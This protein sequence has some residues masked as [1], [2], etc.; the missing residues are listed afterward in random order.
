MPATHRDEVSDPSADLRALRI[1]T[2]AGVIVL[3]TAVVLTAITWI[4]TF[5]VTVSSVAAYLSQIVA[6]ASAEEPVY[7]TSPV[8]FAAKPQATTALVKKEM[9]QEE[10][11][12]TNSRVRQSITTDRVLNSPPA[13]RAL[14]ERSPS[15]APLSPQISVARVESATTQPSRAAQDQGSSGE[16][17]MLAENAVTSAQPAQKPCGKGFW[18][19]IC[20]ERMRWSY[21]HPDKWDMVPK[22]AVQKFDLSY[23]LD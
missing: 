3:V 9:R 17:P 22:C 23:S 7:I 5:L 1:D 11:E 4:T 18:G 13:P 6:V 8:S 10:P 20:E 21:C 14:V 15:A 16:Q 2:P 19:S 12:R